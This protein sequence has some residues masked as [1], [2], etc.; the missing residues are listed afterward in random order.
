VSNLVHLFTA[1]AALGLPATLFSLASA[2]GTDE[3]AYF[4]Q[5]V[6]Q[7]KGQPTPSRLTVEKVRRS[8][9]GLFRLKAAAAG[10]SLNVIVDTGASVVVL[11][12]KDA[13]RAGVR[14]HE[15]ARAT[16]KTV[17]G[18]AAMRWGVISELSVAGHTLHDVKVAVVEKG[19]EASLL[20]QNALSK[21]P[22]LYIEGDT[23]TIG[24][25]ASGANAP[26]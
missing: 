25:L 1:I 9:D 19:L 23:I 20:G 18:G 4:V 2:E 24:Q 22:G 13:S 8:P 17:G 11:T 5:A 3:G 12:E 6:Q 21:L 7:G 14:F 26:D 15:Q 16:I 10:R